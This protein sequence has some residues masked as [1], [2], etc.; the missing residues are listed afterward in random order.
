MAI[1]EEPGKETVEVLFPL[2]FISTENSDQRE[3]TGETPKS[4]TIQN[5]VR[6]K[7]L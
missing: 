7:H 4:K 2:C 1:A 3:T 5:H 6:L